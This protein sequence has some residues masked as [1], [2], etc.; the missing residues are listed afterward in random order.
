[1]MRCAAALVASLCLTAPAAAQEAV[2]AVT[3]NDLVRVNLD[4]PSQSTVVGPHGLPVSVRADGKLFGAFAITCAEGRLLGLHYEL[5]ATGNFDQYLVEYDTATG[6]A[7]IL[8]LLASS[9][10][11]GYVEAI[12]WVDSLGS[13]VISVTPTLASGTFT[14]ELRTLDPDTGASVYLT[15][16][17][18]DNDYAVHD[19]S[20]DRFYTIDANGVGRLTRV[21]LASGANT[22]LGA[23]TPTTADL[24]YSCERD[25]IFAYDVATDELISFADGSAGEAIWLGVFGLGD[26]VQGLA[27]CCD[28]A[29]DCPADLDGD[30]DVDQHDLWA[31]LWAYLCRRPEADLN[32][33]GRVNWRDKIEFLEA[34]LHGCPGDDDGHPGWG[35]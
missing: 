22:D 33:D 31:F 34:Y 14:S 23:V 19:R 17:N 30:G 12:E 24:A 5:D 11:E 29:P 13:L 32:A 26:V 2:Y 15:E 25:E 16:N 6:A 20:R 9:D 4:D 28:E 10:A 1:M 7:D 18:R 27:V 8:M 21:D 35:C 3:F